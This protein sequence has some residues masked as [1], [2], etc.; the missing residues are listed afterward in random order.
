MELR[1]VDVTRSPAGAGWRLQGE[2]RFDGSRP[3]ET[4]W[5]DLPVRD[6]NDVS[7]TGEPWLAALLPVA[8]TLHEPLR[9]PLPVDARLLE[10]LRE[11]LRIWTAWYPSLAMVPIEAEPCDAPPRGRTMAFFSGGVDS[12]FTALR[13]GA[14]DGTPRTERIDDLVFV[15]GFDIRLANERALGNVLPVLERAADALGKPLLT[16][17]TNLRETVFGATDWNQLSHGAALAAVAL[18]MGPRYSTALVPS[19]AGYRDLRFWGSHPLTDPLFTSSRTRIVHDG[20]AFMRAEK[21]EY[22]AQSDIALGALRVCWRS[23][24]GWN[25]QACNNCYRTMLTLEALG[26]LD[27]SATFD[28]ARLDLDRASRIFC[29]RS[30]D[31]RQFGY[32]RDLA[33]RC[34]RPDI[35]R[36]VE[37]SLARSARLSRRIA[38][39]RRLRD[40]PLFWRWAP[41]IERRMLTGWLL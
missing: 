29:P 12:F 35:V 7:T 8:A 9:L 32:V 19:S 24:D 18:A 21:T 28:R 26:V 11:L 34:G 10:N 4:L 6:D 1:A 38:F 22:V 36:A 30:Y 40:R 31:I 16:V 3:P 14:G 17:T 39:V 13:H 20:P 15:H 33:A 27:R 41:A 2:L 37:R 5:F 25:C 23:D